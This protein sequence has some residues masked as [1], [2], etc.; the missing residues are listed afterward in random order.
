MAAWTI[1]VDKIKDLGGEVYL[2]Q[3]QSY[4]EGSCCTRYQRKN[5]KKHIAQVHQIYL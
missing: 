1:I 5:A 4:M 2:N 3:K